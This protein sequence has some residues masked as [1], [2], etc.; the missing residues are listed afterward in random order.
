MLV[1]RLCVAQ[2]YMDHVYDLLN[3]KGGSLAL[4]QGS[5]NVAYVQGLSAHVT[6]AWLACAFCV[7]TL[8]GVR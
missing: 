6:C 2:L 5:D 8:N 7:P 1:A 4:R 3:P